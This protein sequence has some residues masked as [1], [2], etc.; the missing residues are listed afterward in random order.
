M[1][2]KHL[3]TK[4]R[5]AFQSG[6]ELGRL[7]FRDQSL[8]G[9]HL[10]AVHLRQ[11]PLAQKCRANHMGPDSKDGVQRLDLLQWHAIISGGHCPHIESG[12]NGVKERSE[13]NFSGGSWYQHLRLRTTR[14]DWPPRGY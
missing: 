3:I 4:N 11:Q 14:K 13:I 6:V 12:F 7:L 2:L 5:A 1:P 8:T 9:N 10:K